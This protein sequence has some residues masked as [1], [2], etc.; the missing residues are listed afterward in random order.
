MPTFILTPKCTMNL[1]KGMKIEKGCLPFIVEIPYN[2]LPF[3]SIESKQ[4]VKN[5]LLARGLD[6]S[7]HESFL[8]KG[9]FD[10]KKV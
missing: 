1:N 10:Y 2:H 5:A 4:C 6:I 7:G 8:S 3:D 9:Y